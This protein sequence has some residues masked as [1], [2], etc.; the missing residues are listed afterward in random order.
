MDLVKVYPHGLITAT[1]TRKFR[2]DPVVPVRPQTEDERWAMAMVRNHGIE[3]ALAVLSPPPNLDITCELE[4]SQGDSP[5]GLSKRPNSDKPRPRRGLKGITSH[6]RRQVRDGCTVLERRYGRH[7]LSFLTC[8]LPPRYQGM[9]APQWAVAVEG[10]NRKLRRK[11]RREGLPEEVIGVTEI[12]EGRY[13]RYG[14]VALHLHVVFVGKLPKGAWLL[15]KQWLEQCWKECC[16]QAT[17][18]ESTESEFNA[19]T[20]IQ[21]VKRSAAGYLGKYM[22]KGGKIAKAIIDKGLQECL[23]TA[24]YLCSRAMN[25]AIQQAIRVY[26]GR[27]ALELF[28][29]VQLP[30]SKALTYSRWVEIAGCDGNLVKIA[31]YGYLTKDALA[32]FA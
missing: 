4:T 21:R 18:I 1:R 5:L 15:T 17:G 10:L 12:Q 26:S 22:S 3:A 19:A 8:T 30:E 23:P 29:F 32:A 6:G 7:R 16:E 14:A 31:W 25:R 27:F 24:W 11:L 13:E 20:N 28:E 2:P 9:T